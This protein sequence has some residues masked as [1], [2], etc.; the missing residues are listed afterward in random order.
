LI[1]K[2]IVDASA[3]LAVYLKEDDAEHFAR[4]MLNAEAL[5]MSAPCYVEL[6]LAAAS[7]HGA[8]AVDDIDAQLA[9]WGVEIITLD[10]HAAKLAVSAFLRY[11]EGR[12]HPAQLN[13]GDSISYAMSKTE[14]MPLLFKGDDFSHTD[15]ERVS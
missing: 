4:L 8:E 2:V 10:Q 12:G 15:V 13:F 3:I 6:C 9:L 11:G 5:F 7:K 1:A 14:A